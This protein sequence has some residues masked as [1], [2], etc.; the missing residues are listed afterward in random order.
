MQEQFVFVVH[1]E[2]IRKRAAYQLRFSINDQLINRIKELPH[3]TR[4]WNVSDMAWEVTTASLLSLIKKYRNSNKIHFDFGNEDSRKIFIQQIKKVEVVEE[5]KRKFVAD[6]NIKKEH[7]VKYKEE[8]ESTYEQYSDQ[9]HALLK[10]G[11][12]LYPHQIVAAMFMNATRNT[13]I[14]HEMGLGKCQPLYS[15]LLTPNGWIQMGDIIVGDYV[16][17]SDGKPKK[18]L[19]VFPQGVKDIYE[20]NFNDGTSTRCCDEHLWNVNTYIRNWRKNPF[21]TKTLRSI[22][23]EGVTFKNGN[24]KHYIPIVKPIEFEKRE[25]KIDPYI[26]GCLLGD[27]SIISKYGIGFSSL[28]KEI[29]DEISKRLPEK[30]N[31]VINGTSKIDY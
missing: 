7:W 20:V 5:E 14:S 27:G 4:K 28:D 13:L 25:L 11:V 22:M 16:I 31:M 8:L 26:L 29:I 21:Q 15:E 2:R 19:G 10:A 30:H 12:K 23:N 17:G 1:C 3:A 9:M 24:H 6:L 18:V